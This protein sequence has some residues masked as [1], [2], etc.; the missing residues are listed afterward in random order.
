MVGPCVANTQKECASSSRI[1]SRFRSH[2]LRL[3]LSKYDRMGN[4]YWEEV[5]LPDMGKSV[6]LFVRETTV[7]HETFT[8]FMNRLFAS[9]AE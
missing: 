3:A 5:T 6:T 4:L 8:N 7:F 9:D 1:R 2:Q